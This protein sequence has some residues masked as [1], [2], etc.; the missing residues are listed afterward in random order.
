MQELVKE[1]RTWA[2]LSK[3]RLLFQRIIE[4]EEK[5]YC[6]KEKGTIAWGECHDLLQVSHELGE[7]VF[8]L[9]EEQRKLE[10]PE[11]EEWDE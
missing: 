5:D 6:N 11:C 3:E 2:G 10:R 9:R 8:S 7:G 1:K 4:E